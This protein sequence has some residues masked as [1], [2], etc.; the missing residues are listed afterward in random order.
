MTTPLHTRAGQLIRLM[1]S[2]DQVGE[3]AGAAMALNRVITAK[4][5]DIHKFA[6][7]VEV[8]LASAP[9]LVP[10][11]DG[12][13]DWKSVALFC[14]HHRDRLGGKETEFIETILQYR[15]SPTERQMKWLYDIRDRIERERR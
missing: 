13:E 5:M 4:G 12:G 9:T 6:D 7:V 15:R 14:R 2:S 8:A 3:V 1:L 10:L 11:D